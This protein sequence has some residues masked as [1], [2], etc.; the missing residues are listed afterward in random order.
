M[1]E[2]SKF[3]PG[4]AGGPPNDGRRPSMAAGTPRIGLGGLPNDGRRP[5]NRAGFPLMPPECIGPGIGISPMPPIMGPLPGDLPP[6]IEFG[7]G[8][9]NDARR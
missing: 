2:G 9:P 8:P 3:R 5:G 7:I 4:C 1:R 6:I